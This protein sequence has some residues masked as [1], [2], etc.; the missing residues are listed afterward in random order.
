MN[1]F[2]KRYKE[3]G[4][5]LDPE[6][7]SI[8]QSIRVNTLKISE[9][10]LIPRLKKKKIKLKK[11]PF[12]DN[13]YWAESDFSLSSTA[14]YLHGYFYIQ[15]AASQLP[16]KVLL[17]RSCALCNPAESPVKSKSA[18]S[19]EKGESVL[20]MAAAPGSKTTQL[21]QLMKNQGSIVALDSNSARLPALKNNIERCGVK[22][23]VIYQK[24]AAHVAD[25][26]KTFDKVLLDAPCSG[27]FTTDH[28]WFDKR[29]IEG[30]KDQAKVQKSL[31]KAAIN[32]LKPKGALVYSTCSLEPEEDEDVIEW[33]LENLP[34]KLAD[35]GLDV[36][37]PGTTTNTGLCRR[38]WPD[39][40]GT[41]GFFL[42]KLILKS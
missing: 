3:M 39:E 24:D 5:E 4:R 15:E 33:A 32:V 26:G 16:V 27:N 2:L 41:Q 36:G 6:K 8:K 17:Q 38:I 29:S 31:L 40:S 20:D 21:A 35:T 42:G 18:L 13:G 25:L 11:I 28:A 14:E 37:E 10:E 1:F 19:P 7:I 30:I 9:E 12:T 22:N 23:C 34:V